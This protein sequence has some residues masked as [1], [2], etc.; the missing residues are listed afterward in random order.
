MFLMVTISGEPLLEYEP[1][2]RPCV[3]KP[4]VFKTMRATEEDLDWYENLAKS[5]TPNTRAHAGHAPDMTIHGS[6]EDMR[7]ILEWK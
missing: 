2:L 1:T 5:G 4:G 3:E 6:R 7:L